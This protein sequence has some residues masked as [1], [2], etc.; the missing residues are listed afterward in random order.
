MCSRAPPSP[1]SGLLT[2][3][4]SGCSALRS[5]PLGGPPGITTSTTTGEVAGAA[6]GGGPA[7]PPTVP[8]PSGGQLVPWAEKHPAGIQRDLGVGAGRAV[9]GRP[10]GRAGKTARE[11]GRGVPG[12]S[13]SAWSSWAGALGPALWSPPHCPCTRWEAT[14]TRCSPRP[15]HSQPPPHP[16]ESRADSVGARARRDT[17]VGMSEVGAVQLGCELV[18]LEGKTAQSEVSRP[19]PCPLPAKYLPTLLGQ[20]VARMAILPP[21][22]DGLQLA[23][24]QDPQGRCPR[25]LNPLHG[26]QVLRLGTALPCFNGPSMGSADLPT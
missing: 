20:A 17:H 8:T 21:E 12:A 13:A 16:G 7:A 10:E 1:W 22:A 6:P 18:K 19:C 11:G 14:G 23:V 9:L 25:A 3:R 24:P 5:R 15:P 26:A 2:H 4:G